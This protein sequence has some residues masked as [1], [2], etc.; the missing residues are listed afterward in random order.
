MDVS[1]RK[2]AR[3]GCHNEA[4]VGDQ[5]DRGAVALAHALSQLQQ[6]LC[7]RAAPATKDS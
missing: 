3:A 6:L 4:A 5:R 2:H 7:A 1:R